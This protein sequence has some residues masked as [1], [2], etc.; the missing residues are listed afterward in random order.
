MGGIHNANDAIE[1][2]MAGATAV[3]VGTA[4]FHEPDTALQVIR[5]I[6]DFLQRKG[7]Q[8][9]PEIRGPVFTGKWRCQAGIPNPIRD[10]SIINLP[11]DPNQ[12]SRILFQPI[13]DVDRTS[14]FVVAK[15][16]PSIATTNVVREASRIGR[17]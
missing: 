9:V 4:N 15:V 5:G 3:A 7:I 14:D 12:V 1:F 11:L 13:I 6:Q 16:V 10:F 2:I 17:G 8:D